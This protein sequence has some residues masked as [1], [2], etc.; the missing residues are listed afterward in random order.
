M[1]LPPPPPGDTD[2][3]AAASAN[4]TTLQRLVSRLE[5]VAGQL[6]SGDLETEAAAQLV[7]ECAHVASG[8]SAELERLARVA[9]SEPLPGQDQLL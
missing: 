6:R 7:D 5:E 4:T 8:A 9:A 1:T 3:T 2:P